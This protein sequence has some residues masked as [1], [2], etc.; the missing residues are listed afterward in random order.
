DAPFSKD[1]VLQAAYVGPHGV[2][3]A[4]LANLN[5]PL[6]PLDTNFQPLCS[7]CAPTN[8]GRPY[9]T[10]VP[11][12][13]EI[14][15]EAHDYSSSAHTL[16]LKFEKRFSRDWSMLSAYTYQ[17]TIGQ[18]EE[19]EWLE[20]QNTHDLAAER[21]NNGPD[22]RHQFTSAWSYQLPI[23]PNQRFLNSNGPIRWLTGGWQLNGIIAM[24]SGQAFTP[25]LSFDPT[26][27]NSGAPRRDLI[28]NPYDF[29][30]APTAGCPSNRQSSACWYTPA[31]VAIPQTAPGQTFATVFGNARRGILRGPAQYNVDFSVFKNFQINET[32]NLQ[33]RA[34]AF[35][36]FNTPEFGLPYNAV[37][38][39][40]LAGSIS[41]T[42]HPPRQLQL[43]LKL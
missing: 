22:Y 24:Y 7:G 41:S 26:N 10:S 8:I 11:D 2:K 1:M 20:P 29:S 38:A 6:Q 40:G 25:L 19:N 18:T 12:V 17:H 43:A 3:L 34:E 28:G 5:Q 23:G 32:W 21:G 9:F 39:T 36:L 13:G 42:V 31:A 27:T 30:N 4:P 35:N 16:Q 37:D 33:F 15:T 14:R